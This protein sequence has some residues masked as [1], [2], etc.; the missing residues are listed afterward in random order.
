MNNPLVVHKDVLGMLVK[1]E[2][3]QE[4]GKVIAVYTNQLGFPFFMVLL[5]NK[6]ITHAPAFEWVLNQPSL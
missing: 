3:R 6:N 5:N 1:H 2:T 4:S